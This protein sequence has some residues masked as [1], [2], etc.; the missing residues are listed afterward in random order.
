MAQFGE[1]RGWGELPPLPIGR[2]GDE[3]GRG[4]RANSTTSSASRRINRGRTARRDFDIHR[5]TR[6]TWFEAGIGER[7][8]RSP[9]NRSC[10]EA[11][12]ELNPES[13]WQSGS[14]VLNRASAERIEMLRTA[15]G[16]AVPFAIIDHFGVSPQARTVLATLMLA[17]SLVPALDRL[18]ATAIPGAMLKSRP[19]SF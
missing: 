12:C 9:R 8:R 5:L 17:G 11:R 2:L 19:S 4:R 18:R 7:P 6:A 1:I 3:S 16:V 13:C 15:A 14:S 10:G